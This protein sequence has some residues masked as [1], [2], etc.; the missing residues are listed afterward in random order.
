MKKI[1]ST[2]AV[3]AISSLALLSSCSNDKKGSSLKPASPDAVVSVNESTNKTGSNSLY[4]KRDKTSALIQ[5]NG[6]SL[7]TTD[8]K[9]IYVFK[10]SQTTS[11]N[12]TYVTYNN[13]GFLQDA[14]NNY[15][16]DIPAKQKNNVSLTLKVTLDANNI[17]AV[18][19]E[20]YFVFTDGTIFDA[21]SSGNGVFLGPAKIFIVY[22]ALTETTG[23]RL[24]N[25]KGPNSGSF[26][27]VTL[28]NR[29]FADPANSKDMN[30]ADANTEF[31]DKSFN[32]GTS[33]TLYVKLPWDFD[34]VNATDL[35]LKAAYKAANNEIETQSSVIAGYMYVAKIR[36]LDQYVFI[37]ITSNSEEI[38]GTGTGKNNEF[39]EFSVKK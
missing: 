8:M 30:D 39:M 21:P 33:G 23:H 36:G 22:G 1:Y 35:T 7:T 31:W 24:N 12:G 11:S 20:Y 2:I 17:V 37:K 19:D 32:A 27:L 29:S 15:Y 9:R 10:K 3:L 13:A 16:Y 18:M 26:D 4:V 5:V 6:I 34:Y 14:N 28:T 38:N 25:I